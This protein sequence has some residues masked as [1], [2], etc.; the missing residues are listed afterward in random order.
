MPYEYCSC[1]GA[2]I[3]L[4]FPPVILDIKIMFLQMEN[5]TKSHKTLGFIDFVVYI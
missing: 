2:S 1:F 3:E 4:H 5:D